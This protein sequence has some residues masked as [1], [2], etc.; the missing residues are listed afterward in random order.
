MKLKI[1][2][3][4]EAIVEHG[5][6]GIMNADQSCQCTG[7]TWIATLI[8]AGVRFSMRR[9]GRYLDDIFIQRLWPSLKQQAI[10]LEEISDG[11]Q[12]RCK[13][14]D[15]MIFCNTKRP[16]TALDRLTPDERHRVGVNENNAT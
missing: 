5:Q 4:N 12:A 10:Y 11:S 14:K 6:P 8:E 16:H 2:A 13:N 1:D 3:L 9:R 15:R 7:S